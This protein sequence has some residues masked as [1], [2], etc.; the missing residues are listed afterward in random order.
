MWPRNTAAFSASMPTAERLCG[1][2]RPWL[3]E[4]RPATITG[5]VRWSQR[6]ASLQL[7]SSILKQARTTTIYVVAMSKDGSG[8]YH[9]RL[10][11]LDVTTGAEEFGGPREIQAS[12]PGTGDNSTGGKVIFAPGQ[13]EE[14][15]GVLLLNG[16]VYTAWT[17]HC[18]IRPYTGWIMGFDQSTLAQVSVL[19]VTPNGNEGAIWMSGSGLAADSAGNIFLLD[20]NGTL[21]LPSTRMGFRTRAIMETLSSNSQ[22]PTGNCRWL[23]TL[24]CSIKRRKTGRTKIWAL[25]ER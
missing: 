12:F 7:Q 13:Y 6:S 10:H 1:K 2:F 8:N 17:S 23:T 24:K 3:R 11:A 19:N 9:Q 4:K 18:D 5:A 16:V 14:R 20:A 25:V 22:P 21:T 15:A